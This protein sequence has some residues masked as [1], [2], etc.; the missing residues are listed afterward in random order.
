MIEGELTTNQK[1]AIA[2]EAIAAEA[3]KLGITVCRPNLDARYDLIFDL[4]SRLLRVQ[5]K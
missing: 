3:V 2:E 5:C 4:G 1:G